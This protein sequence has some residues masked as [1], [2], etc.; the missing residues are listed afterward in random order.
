MKANINQ[1][2]GLLR[3][4]LAPLY[5]VSGDEPLLVQEACDSIRKA[6]RQAGFEDRQVYH[7]D[8]HL[9]W[10]AVQ[11]DVGSLSLFAAQRRI[12]IHLPKGKLGDGRNLVENFL[13]D[14]PDDVLILLDQSAAGR[15]RDPQ[16][17]A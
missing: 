2:D 3:K 10:N 17:L 13:K 11:D 5:L 1:L 8:N 14:P 15:R 12:E 9:D 16:A 4:S 6:A 7:A